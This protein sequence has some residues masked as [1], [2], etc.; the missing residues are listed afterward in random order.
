[1]TPMP[2]LPSYLVFFS[3]ALKRQRGPKLP[4]TGLLE[5]TQGFTGLTNLLRHRNPTP[6]N[7]WSRC[8]TTPE[9]V[10]RLEIRPGNGRN[11]W[12]GSDD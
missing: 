9:W 6:S 7:H 2:T 1:M 3:L 11:D 5:R 12:N 4:L 8:E 10:T